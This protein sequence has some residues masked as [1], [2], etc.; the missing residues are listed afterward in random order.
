MI[1]ADTGTLVPCTGLDC[2]GADDAHLDRVDHP[3]RLEAHAVVSSI[4]R[5][6]PG[7][8]LALFSVLRRTPYSPGYRAELSSGQS[9]NKVYG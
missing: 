4:S 3:G 8:L 2:P 1:R 6:R 7:Y 9:L 5:Y